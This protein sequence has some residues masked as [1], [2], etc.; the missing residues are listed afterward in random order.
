MPELPEEDA[1]VPQDAA[2]EDTAPAPEERAAA[3]DDAVFAQLVAGF[4]SPVDDEARSWPAAEDL[5][6]LAPAPRPRPVIKPLPVVRA[7]PPVDPRAWIPQESDEDDHY[8]PPPPPPL[9]RTETATRLAVA[10]VVAG[11]ALTL[12][13]AFGQLPGVGGMGAFLGIGLFVGGVATLIARMRVDDDE[14]EDD[15]PQRGAV[16]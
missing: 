3:D 2:G 9:P 11:V 10:A 7:I 15:D 1:D 13:S 5:A 4:D 6:E 16:V 12:Y 14:D 8:V